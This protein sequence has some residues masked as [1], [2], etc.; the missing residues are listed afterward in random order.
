MLDEEKESCEGERTAIGIDPLK[1]NPESRNYYC[2]KK[3]E[4]KTHWQAMNALS[5]QLIKIIYLM[6][7]NKEK[8]IRK[9]L[10][11]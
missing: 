2:R 11:H 3:R 5:R 1:L 8:Y 9:Y 10:I 4:G 7:K 6:L